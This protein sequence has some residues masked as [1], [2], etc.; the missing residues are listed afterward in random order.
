MKKAD[1]YRYTES[2]LY[3]YIRN[4]E[5]YDALTAEIEILRNSGD[6]RAQSYEISSHSTGFS[7]PVEKY[8]H[9]LLK[10]EDKLLRLER[11]IL[12]VRELHQE[13]IDEQ[14]DQRQAQQLII[15]EKYYFEN[16][17]ARQIQ[18]DYKMPQ[19]TFRQCRKELVYYLRE[20]LL[21]DK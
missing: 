10:L 14:T 1:S 9:V 13:L 4:I 20:M 12:P 5:S 7:A 8:L 21:K 17:P 6:V 19:W 3:G 15:M 16:I 18:R 11:K 2:F